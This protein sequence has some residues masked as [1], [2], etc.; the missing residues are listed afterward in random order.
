MVAIL[1]TLL[2]AASVV[3][4]VVAAP[5]E[6]K[7]M[8]GLYQDLAKRDSGD[9]SK[10]QQVEPGQGTHDGFFYSYW[11]DG[12]GSVTFTNGPGGQY[13][14][15]WQNTGNFV[16]GKGW[17]PGASRSI[18][19]S[20]TWNPSGNSYLAVYGWTQNPLIEYY[21]VESFSTYNP[22]TGAQKLGEIQSDGGTYEI[23]KTTRYNQPSIEGTATFDQFWSIRTQHRTSG[24]VT[25]QNHFNAWA[26]A[27]LQLG[28]HNYQI[29]A[30]EGYQSS[31]SASV[32]VQGP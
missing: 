21:V 22:S 31:G 32:T 8:L 7:G 25:I 30:T 20:A 24:T 28:N 6:Y 10:R 23:Y 9:I 16:G 11:T 5:S 19:Y 12:G 15:N 13:S 3:S 27:G 29:V 18:S 2:L 17:N 4:G 1:S 26:Q 14:V